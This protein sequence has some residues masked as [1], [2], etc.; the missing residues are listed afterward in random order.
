MPDCT[1]ALPGTVLEQ[2]A[3]SSF[4]CRI[5][6][7]LMASSIRFLLRSASADSSWSRNPTKLLPNRTRSWCTESGRSRNK[8]SS[9][10]LAVGALRAEPCHRLRRRQLDGGATVD[11]HHADRPGADSNVRPGRARASPRTD[12]QSRHTTTAADRSGDTAARLGGS[13]S[14]AHRHHGTGPY[15]PTQ[16]C[17]RWEAA[18]RRRTCSTESARPSRTSPCSSTARADRT[19]RIQL[20]VAELAS[21][22]RSSVRMAI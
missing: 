2:I 9:R 5:L 19:D 16:G 1:A 3:T 11:P 8:I 15:C 7:F 18:H 4:S 12:Q 20:P 22:N 21:L 13:S 14:S 10:A 6:A 17:S